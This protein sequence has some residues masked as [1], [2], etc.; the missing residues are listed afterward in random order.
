[1]NDPACTFSKLK[2]FVNSHGMNNAAADCIYDH[3]RN[4]RIKKI[5]KE[6]NQ[7]LSLHDIDAKHRLQSMMES[8]ESYEYWGGSPL[9]SSLTH[10]IDDVVDVPMHLLFLGIVKST[11]GYVSSYLKIKKLSTTF[12]N[13]SKRK[14]S[15]MKEY[16]L[17]WFVLI[18]FKPS[19]DLFDTTGWVG[20]NFL[21]FARIF[22]W[23]ISCLRLISYDD[24]KQTLQPSIKPIDL[25]TRSELLLFCEKHNI[26][27]KRNMKQKILIRK[28]KES[29]TTNTM[30]PQI[31]EKSCCNIEDVIDL[32]VYQERIIKYLMGEST[33][34][35]RNLFQISVNMFMTKLHKLCW[36]LGIDNI[37]IRMWN[38]Q[39]LMN[40]ADTYE[41]FG[42]F[43]NIWEGGYNGEGVI[44]KIKRE[45]PCF[46]LDRWAE[47]T[48]TKVYCRR[49]Q[50]VIAND[51][52]GDIQRIALKKPSYI[53]VSLFDIETRLSK[54]QAISALCNGLNY[55]VRIKDEELDYTYLEIQISLRYEDDIAKWYTVMP[56]KIQKMGGNKEDIT[57]L[58]P[59]ILAPAIHRRP[60]E[61]IQNVYCK[62]CYNYSE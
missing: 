32:V 33:S 52:D 18:S 2:S 4:K 27:H 46:N 55:Y 45:K 23:Y 50:G 59:I 11:I 49:A 60:S 17:S 15:V 54:H 13:L 5:I 62:I 40:L 28:V 7:H 24:N 43:Q 38:F 42:P 21:A 57:H 20:E 22:K 6:E 3:I 56:A 53:Y 19:H 25:W 10:D 41:R 61:V 36:Y 9:W 31:E 44:K 1:M 51:C 12:E 37:A 8:N 39:S 26:P 30:I 48:L 47:I 34:W 58:L 29:N 16:G 35:S 14:L